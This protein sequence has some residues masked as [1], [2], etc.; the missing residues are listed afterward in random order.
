MM[1][2]LRIKYQN[3]YLGVKEFVETESENDRITVSKMAAKAYFTNISL[4]NDVIIKNKV[5]NYM[6]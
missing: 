6:F 3:L 1:L 5:S 4:Y 2:S